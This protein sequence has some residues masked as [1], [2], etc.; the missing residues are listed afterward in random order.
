[1]LKATRE[2]VC[3]YLTDCINSA[4]YD[5]KFPNELKEADLSPLFKNDDS[6]YKGNFRPISVLPAA[7]KVYERLLK[8]QICPYFQDKLSEILCGFR[9]GYST[10]HAL[11]RLIEKWRK[12]LDASGIVGTILMDLSKAYDCLPHDLLIAKLEAYGFDFNSLCLMYSY[13]DCRHQRV[14]IGSHR[15]TA[16]RIKIG[17]PQ[18]SV[19]GPLLFN[20]FIN[21]LCLMRLDSEICNFAD[22]NTI[23]SCGIDL[24]E[25][26]T[27]LESDLSRLLEWFTNNGMVANPKKFQLM[28]LGLKGQRRLRLNINENKLSVTDHV[29]LLGIE[30]D[31]KLKF[32]KHVKT[33]CSKVNKKISAFY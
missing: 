15:S 18:G 14:K 27:N 1:M 9:E 8:D 3:P 7:S 33:L 28:F 26:V 32:N 11:I 24:H 16:K 4:V 23:Y 12:C 5:C 22:D 31:N 19:L 2:I 30:V 29:K 6:N 25:I 20:I 10:Q 21:D 13:L 17:V